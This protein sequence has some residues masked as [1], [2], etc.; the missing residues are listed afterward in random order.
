MSLLSIAFGLT[1][2]GSDLKTTDLKDGFVRVETPKYVI[3]VPK[4]WEV[5]EETSF[6]QRE[7]N[8]GGM[9]TMTG[10]RTK[11][12][13]DELYKTSLYFIR[14]GTKD[15]PTPFRLGKNKKGY[16]TMS[17]EMVN[18]DKQPSSKYVILKNAKAEILAL[19]IKIKSPKSE[20]EMDKIFLRLISTADIK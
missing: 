1:I 2:L 16:E 18:K 9:T 14:R 10:G 5:G 17:F 19:S 11:A 20:K 4:G 15:E 8:G 7:I 12:T 13:W 3:E 6:G